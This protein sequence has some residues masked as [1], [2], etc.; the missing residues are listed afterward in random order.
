MRRFTEIKSRPDNQVY[1]FLTY[2]YTTISINDNIEKII[3]P[4]LNNGEYFYLMNNLFVK[5]PLFNL[6]I[7]LI[8]LSIYS[9]LY[10]NYEYI[11]SILAL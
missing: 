1:H 3:D 9:W 6:N 7:W 2:V 10:G 8:S 11:A 5:F 4:Q